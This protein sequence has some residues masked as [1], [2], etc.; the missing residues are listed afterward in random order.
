MM[1]PRSPATPIGLRQ[2]FETAR[3]IFEQALQS[4]RA[5]AEINSVQIQLK[6]LEQS[7]GGQQSAAPRR[8]TDMNT[9]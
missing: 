6:E 8:I 9:R 1:D 3:K 5:M 7:L 2:Q 4:R